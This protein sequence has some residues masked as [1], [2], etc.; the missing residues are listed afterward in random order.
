MAVQTVK[1][2]WKKSKDKH[3][4]LLDY[5]TTPLASCKLSPA[6]L[7]MGRRPRNLLPT[8][9]PLLQPKSYDTTDIRQRFREDKTKQKH[10]YDNKSGKPLPALT[11]GDP[12]RMTPL[13]GS[14]QTPS[15]Q[16]QLGIKQEL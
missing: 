11:P 2:L 15:L 6:Q 3:L 14:K 7:L 10:Y 9:K 12:V 4:A 16:S 1:M 8:A 13:P 5:R